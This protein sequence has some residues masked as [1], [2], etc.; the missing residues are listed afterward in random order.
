VGQAWHGH[1]GCMAHAGVRWGSDGPG[2]S[3]PSLLVDGRAGGRTR[4]RIEGEGRLDSP[5]S[6][7]GLTATAGQSG[8]VAG[9][10]RGGLTASPS[11]PAAPP[12]PASPSAL[13]ASPFPVVG[14]GAAGS[15]HPGT[16]R[17]GLGLAEKGQGGAVWEKRGRQRVVGLA[18]PPLHRCGDRG[19]W[20]GF[21]EWQP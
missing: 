9:S 10:S 18:A 8:G 14:F 2:P 21:A 16:A 3:S 17:G 12:S 4:Q 1:A 13:A 15:G 20:R 7:S 6:G 11:A 19:W 5:T